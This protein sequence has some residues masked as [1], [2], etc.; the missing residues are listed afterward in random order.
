VK[1]VPVTTSPAKHLLPSPDARWS[2]QR[3]ASVVAAVARGE[4]SLD[5]AC[6]RYLLTMEEFT[7]WQRAANDSGL[8]G[9]MARRPR[10]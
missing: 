6:T 5:Q 7:A 8:K 2:A 9:L 10:A 4:I 3:K 1:A